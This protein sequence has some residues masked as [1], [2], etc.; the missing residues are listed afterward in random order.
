MCVTANTWIERENAGNYTVFART[1]I[2]YSNFR[3]NNQCT[4]D[5]EYTIVCR[6]CVNV[7]N[8]AA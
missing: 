8:V 2:V 5:L 3:Y 1:Y 6:F 7:D 4:F